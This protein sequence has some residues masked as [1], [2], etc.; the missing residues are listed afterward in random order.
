MGR[1]KYNFCFVYMKKT[2]TYEAK[3]IQRI[4]NMNKK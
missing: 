4:I 3:E 2:H 1:T